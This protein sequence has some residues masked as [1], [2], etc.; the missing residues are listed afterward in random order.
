MDADDTRI[1]GWRIR[2]I[3]K[4]RDKSL[5]VIAGLPH[6]V[7]LDEGGSGQEDRAPC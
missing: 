1:I 4:A 6:P 2:R 7:K 5:Q 3:R